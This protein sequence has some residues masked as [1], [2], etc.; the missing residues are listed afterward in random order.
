M[1]PDYHTGTFMGTLIHWVHMGT[2]TSRALCKFFTNTPLTWQNSCVRQGFLSCQPH[3]SAINWYSH[4]SPRPMHVRC[5]CR[6]T[7]PGHQ[8]HETLTFV[9]CEHDVGRNQLQILRVVQTS[10]NATRR[11]TKTFVTKQPETGN[12]RNLP[13][14]SLLPGVGLQTSGT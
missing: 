6:S 14:S 7:K 5:D 10:E 11:L 13:K 12:N 9:L 3:V 4:S 8:K 1:I 2:Q